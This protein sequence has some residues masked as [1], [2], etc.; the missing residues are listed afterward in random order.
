MQT[1]PTFCT[2][3]EDWVSHRGRLYK[4]GTTFERDSD[5]Y[6]SGHLETPGHW[7]KFKCPNKIH[8]YLFI[9]NKVFMILTS[10]EL[11][12]KRNRS[13]EREPSFKKVKKMQEIG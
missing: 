4:K 9:P 6:T 2:L 3:K 5:L 10:A 13:Q 12:T 1:Y 7:Y 11:T 8:G